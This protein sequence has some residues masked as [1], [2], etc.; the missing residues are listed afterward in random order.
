MP[1]V[2]LKPCPFCGASAY[3]SLNDESVYIRC[4]GCEVKTATLT[5]STKY[6]AKDECI[7][8]WNKRM[9]GELNGTEYL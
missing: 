9:K 7:K 3:L 1:D 8:A 6:C 5:A 2:Q 4:R